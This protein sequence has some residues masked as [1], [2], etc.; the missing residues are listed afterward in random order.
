M[1]KIIF[2]VIIFCSVNSFNLYANKLCNKD[3]IRIEDLCKCLNK[4]LKKV[5]SKFAAK[6]VDTIPIRT[7]THH[8]EGIMLKLDNGDI[9]EIF[10]KFKKDVALY[11]RL[12]VE[13]FDFALIEKLNVR[14]I[15]YKR[16]GEILKECGQ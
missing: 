11:K 8:L 9:L 6:A 5:T 4:S 12:A 1:K 3:S 13:K 10:P 14:K 7:Y 2:W 16:N 15:R